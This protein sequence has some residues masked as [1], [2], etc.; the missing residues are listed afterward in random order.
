MAMVGVHHVNLRV[1]DLDAAVE[2]YG[3]TLG[4]DP[5]ERPPLGGE[6]A[7]FRIGAQQLHLSGGGEPTTSKQHFA[8]E[9][10]DL[11]AIV[12]SLRAGGLDVLTPQHVRG[13]G[14]QAFVRD[15]SG[16]RLELN[17]PDGPSPVRTLFLDAADD[18]RRLLAMPEVASR[19]DEPSAL[20]GMTIGTV[21]AH[22]VRAATRTVDLVT[23]P[24]APVPDAG[25]TDASGY[26]ASFGPMDDPQSEL[27]RGIV[28]RSSAEAAAGPDAVLASFDAGLATLRE[29]LPEENPGR[30]VDVWGLTLALD[31]YLRTRVVELAV[32][33]DDL[34]TSLGMTVSLD[35]AALADAAA[36]L[37]GVGALRFGRL[38]VL[39]ALA[40]RE[41]DI[42]EA[43]RV[44]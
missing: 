20:A 34:A 36:V 4:L 11:D 21:A 17:Q 33:V 27:N 43:L 5:I 9:V 22:L 19:W 38:A 30:L 41:R 3:T 26:Y 39:R 14:R 2:F 18:A 10:D 37:A 1:H 44:L 7:W 16:N 29:R 15:P 35:D 12:A 8:V 6:G 42:D 40:R 23:E 25:L 31:E 24:P 28:E 32:H 13:A